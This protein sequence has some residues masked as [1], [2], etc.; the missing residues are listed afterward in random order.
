ML[1]TGTGILLS[2]RRQQKRK[3]KFFCLLL[4]L[5]TFCISLIKKSQKYRNQGFSYFFL[6]LERSGSVQEIRD[7]DPGAHKIKDPADPGP[8]NG[9][10]HRLYKIVL[11]FYIYLGGI[12]QNQS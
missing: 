8:K 4:T 11:L 2:S 9:K 3:N 7:P 12:T 6:L 5:G 10:L 1:R